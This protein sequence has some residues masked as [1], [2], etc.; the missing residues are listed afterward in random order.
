MPLQR[1]NNNGKTGW[2][3]GNSGKCYTGA[4]GRKRAIQQMR[5][6][7]ASG[8]TGNERA[9]RTRVVPSNPLK[10]DP[11]RT[12]TLRRKFLA[13]FGRR[14]RQLQRELVDLVV[15][16]DAFGL[17]IS[18]NVEQIELVGTTIVYSSPK[19]VQQKIAFNQRWN[20]RSTAEQVAAF[21]AWLKERTNALIHPDNL[22]TD[23]DTVYWQ[24]YVEEGYRKGAGRAFTDTRRARKALATSDEQLAFY[25]GTKDEFLRSAFARPEAVDKVKLLAGR[26]FTDLNGVTSDMAARMSRDLADGLVQGQNPRTIARKLSKSIGISRMRA[27][28]IARTE[29][30]RAH[31]EGQL[32]AMEQLGVAEVGVAVEWSTAGDDRV[33]EMCAPLEGVVFSIQ[34]ARGI[35]PRHPNCRC[36]H[37][38]ANVGEPT[39][40]QKRSRSKIQAS[41]AR[42]IKAEVPARGRSITTRKQLSRWPGAGKTIRKN[43]PRSIV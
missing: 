37:I 10:A 4:N 7:R 6:I 28:R 35:I 5:A 8:Y 2:R 42:S 31:A 18:L 9:K 27:E 19:R 26:V 39:K 21:A 11:T 32:D 23:L 20:F 29:I 24:Q 43:R 22:P 34:E 3:W 12:A 41:I 30:I 13:D 1:C 16:E 36:A 40:E 17:T 14:F 38:P 33:C 25:E 15:D